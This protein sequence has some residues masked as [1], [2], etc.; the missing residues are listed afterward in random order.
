MSWVVSEGSV[1]RRLSRGHFISRY[2]CYGVFPVMDRMIRAY[3]RCSSI[4][5]VE[6]VTWV[7][8]LSERGVLACLVFVVGG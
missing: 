2:R 6:I 7:I 1:A 4:R 8:C 3:P 5:I